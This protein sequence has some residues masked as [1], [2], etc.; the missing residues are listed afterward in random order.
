MYLIMRFLYNSELYNYVLPAE[1]HTLCCLQV[2]EGPPVVSVFSTCDLELLSPL[3]VCN[4]PLT[5]ELKF[6]KIRNNL[7]ANDMKI[8]IPFH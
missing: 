6:E 5:V 4:T 8:F 3:I 1:A 2:R 7:R